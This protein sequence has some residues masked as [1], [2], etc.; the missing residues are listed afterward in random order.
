LPV[1]LHHGLPPG[2]HP[3][4]EIDHLI[5]PCLGGSNDFSNLSPSRRRGI[6]PI[7]NAEAKDIK[8]AAA[9]N[10]EKDEV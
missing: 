9:K 7:W 2:F 5:P 6:E 1:R 3:D 10:A 4:Y 8:N